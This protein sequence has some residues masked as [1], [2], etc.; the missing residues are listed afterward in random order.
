MNDETAQAMREAVEAD[1]GVRV[2]ALLAAGSDAL[3][4]FPVHESHES[5]GGAA[6]S[7]GALWH[8]AGRGSVRALS[9]LIAGGADVGAR[10]D[11]LG[12]T[13]LHFAAHYGRPGTAEALL[14]FGAD[15]KAENT[16][17]QTP[18]AAARKALRRARRE[19]TTARAAEHLRAVELL[20][21][22]AGESPTPAT[23][24][25]RRRELAEPRPRKPVRPPAH[26]YEIARLPAEHP[27]GGKRER[28][29]VIQFSGRE[30]A[31]SRGVIY[32]DP[33]ADAADEVLVR[34]ARLRDVTVPVF[35]RRGGELKEFGG[36]RG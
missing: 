24:A 4:A 18:L 21:A 28:W 14:A 20:E 17:G 2:V 1:D 31:R 26:R 32:P 22:A 19:E 10:E 33:G 27:S 6:Y 15:P 34:R 3:G 5:G 16:S 25:R 8:A 30:G 12:D 36:R 35:V 7:L 29:H 11:T 13:P 23:I 9:A